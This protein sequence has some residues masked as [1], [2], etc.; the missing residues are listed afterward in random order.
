MNIHERIEEQTSL[1]KS[2]AEDGAFFS[3][4]RVLR[5][6]ALEVQAHALACAK[7]EAEMIRREGL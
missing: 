2:Y 3:A 5:G 1:A 6:L 4:A 7:A